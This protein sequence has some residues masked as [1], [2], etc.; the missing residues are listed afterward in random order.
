MGEG[1]LQKRAQLGKG[2]NRNSGIL[3]GGRGV[4]FSILVLHGD[5]HENVFEGGGVDDALCEQLLSLHGVQSQ[6]QLTQTGALF[7]DVEKQVSKQPRAE[8]VLQFCPCEL[9]GQQ[10]AHR[11]RGR[12]GR[13]RRGQV[14]EVLLLLKRGPSDNSRSV[15]LKLPHRF[16][17]S[18][19]NFPR[20]EIVA[21]NV[22]QL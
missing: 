1:C 15:R 5:L 13:G 19:D 6:E 22:F 4:V 17:A 18:Q 2:E 9:L 14:E 16:Q 8:A 21:L 3:G 20:M 11:L 7:G 12:V 10:G